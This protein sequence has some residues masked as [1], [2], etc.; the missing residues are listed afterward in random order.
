MRDALRRGE[1][2][3]VLAARVR[4]EAARPAQAERGPC[5][6]PAQLALRERSVR[7]EDDHDRAA[8]AGR[9]RS[10]GVSDGAD[11]QVQVPPAP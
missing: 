4:A 11:E 1:R 8:R 2:Q 9:L 7:A 3:R 10:S 5:G 6:Q